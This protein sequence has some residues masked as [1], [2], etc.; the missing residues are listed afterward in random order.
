[1]AL[2]ALVA[3]DLRSDEGW[4]ESVYQDHLGFWTIG[5]GFLVDARKQGRIPREVADYWLAHEIDRLDT[6]LSNA[7]PWF[8]DA[9]EPVQRALMNMGYQLGVS[10]LLRF[11][12][13]LALMEQGK[14]AEAADQALQSRWAEQTPN[15]ARRVTGW[16]RSAA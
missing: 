16:I 6:R 13:T 14:W 7:L 10:G 4:R 15:R 1:M 9:P 5:Y 3:A 11:R 2:T 12:Q 8:D